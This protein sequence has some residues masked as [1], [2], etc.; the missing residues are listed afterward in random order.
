MLAAMADPRT[1]SPADRARAVPAGERSRASAAP[2]D[3]ALAA[4][5]AAGDQAAFEAVVVR[6][7]HRVF[8]FCLRMLRDRAEAEDVAQEV[9]L[10]F[11]RHAGEFRG[12][13]ALSTWLFRI[14]RNHS[15]NRIKHLDRRGRGAS[16]SLEALAE[17]QPGV[18]AERD[19]V[20]ADDRIAAAETARAVQAAIGALAEDHRAVVVLRDLEDLSYEEIAE[21]TGLPVGTVKSRIH[22][23][24]SALAAHLTRIFR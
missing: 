6:H 19:A 21:V 24:R 7:Q 22:R 3:V 11:Y 16:R 2:D 18:L 8:A 1:H 4:R 12:D 14:A 23:A 20:G 17:E 10:A 5:V 15:L 13:A 9:F